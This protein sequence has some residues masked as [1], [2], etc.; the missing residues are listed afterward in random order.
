MNVDYQQIY[1]DLRTCKLSFDQFMDVMSDVYST[2][3]KNGLKAG[4]QASPRSEKAVHCGP[5]KRLEY[6]AVF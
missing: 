2:G 6:E 3:Y 1:T 5:A 4:E